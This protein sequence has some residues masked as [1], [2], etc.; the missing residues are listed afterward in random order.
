MGWR[1]CNQA[2]LGE[3]IGFVFVCFRCA[4]IILSMFI[5]NDAVNHKV[6]SICLGFGLILNHNAGQTYTELGTDSGRPCFFVKCVLFD[7]I[8]FNVSFTYLN[9]CSTCVNKYL[10]CVNMYVT[11]VN[12]YLTFLNMYVTHLNMY[13][14]CYACVYVLKPVLS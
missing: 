9:M 6:S 14:T 7:I 1:A 5:K 13:C 2:D 3:R 12:M 4:L 10:T 8:G 11:N